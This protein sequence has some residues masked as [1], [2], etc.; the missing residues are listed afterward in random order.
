MKAAEYLEMFK[1]KCVFRESDKPECGETAV[2]VYI[3]ED[4]RQEGLFVCAYHANYAEHGGDG[5][6]F[7]EEKKD[8]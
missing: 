3:T 4:D 7:R 1:V 8:G 6:V 5:P 2:G